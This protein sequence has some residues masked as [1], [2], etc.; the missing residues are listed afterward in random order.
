[1]SSYFATRIAP[2]SSKCLGVIAKDQYH[3]E[4][5]PFYREE[6]LESRSAR[7]STESAAG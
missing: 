1:M 6:E 4:N 7:T 5:E 3:R 2:S